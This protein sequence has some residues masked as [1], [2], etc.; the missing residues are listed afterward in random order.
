MNSQLGVAIVGVAPDQWSGAAHIPALDATEGLELVRLVTSS[1]E[2]A[3]RAAEKW[4]VAASSELSDALADESVNIITVTLRVA[5]HADIVR[6][7]IA[8][9]KHVYCEW[10]LGLTTEEAL[11]LAALSAE[12]PDTV[13][14]VGLQG[15]FSPA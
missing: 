3:A 10:P 6:A 2:S 11:E 14:V 8:A 13:H 1:P 15:R 5:K 7:A 4:G 9:G 12:H